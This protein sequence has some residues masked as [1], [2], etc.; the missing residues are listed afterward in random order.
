MTL[1]MK[2]RMN[3]IMVLV[4]FT[5]TLCPTLLCAQEVE[6][7]AV[8]VTRFEYKK[9]EDVIEIMDAAKK[10]NFNQI[11][12][13]V[14]GNGTV[15]YKSDIEPWAWE[16][17][18]TTVTLTGKD[19]GWD[20]LKVAIEEGHKRGLQIHAYMN[21]C[22]GW[23]KLASPPPEANQLWT[24]HPDWFMVGKDGKRMPPIDP[25]VKDRVREWY[26]F[27]NPA[28]P[29]VRD[30]LTKVFVE[31]VKNYDLDGIHYDYVRYPGEIGDFSYDPVTLEG[32]KKAYGITPDQDKDKWIEYRSQQIV[33]LIKS[34]KTET[35]KLKPNLIIS[36]SV[37]ST[38]E[39]AK[40]YN[41]QDSARFLR[42]GLVDI[43]IPMN[44]TSDMAKFEENLKSYLAVQAKKLVYSGMS[45]RSAIEQIKLSRELKAPGVCIFAFGSTYRNGQFSELG[46]ALMTD[47]FK[48]PAVPPKIPE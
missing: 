1:N 14:R 10:M 11:L 23:H 28:K 22:P 19:P 41:C 2:R 31:V 3:V 6:G 40:T 38:P 26:S 21:V 12:F 16:L 47:L 42:E 39:R 45:G 32:F 9:P 5:L 15:F 4:V 29:E 30:Y 36:A 43:A 48:T 13:Q 18:G 35:R 34:I 24:E 33:D 25:N 46:K 37:G 17:S 27:V 44:Y 20:P 8:W 7:R